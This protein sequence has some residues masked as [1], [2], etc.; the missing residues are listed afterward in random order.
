[1]LEFYAIESPLAQPRNAIVGHLISAVIGVGISKL[2]Q[3]SP[4]FE[5][6]QWLGAALACATATAVMGLTKTVHPPAGATALMAVAEPNILH[7]GWFLLPVLIVG[8]SLMMTVALVV[9]NIAR[10]FP[11]YWWTGEDL[12]KQTGDNTPQCDGELPYHNKN[13]QTDMWLKD[14]SVSGNEETTVTSS[15]T[16][17]RWQDSG[18]DEDRDVEGGMSVFQ[19]VDTCTGTSTVVLR[20]GQ[21]SLPNHLSVS[22]EE[23]R[24]LECICRRL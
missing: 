12:S 6:I 9:N 4:N 23:R 15:T 21:L 1:M 5:S 2:F 10:R 22:E 13:K 19:H 3:L 20:Q 8:I 7:L 16:H 18:E 17:T 24:V 14:A 11:V